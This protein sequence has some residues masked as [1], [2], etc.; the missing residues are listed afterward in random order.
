MPFQMT[1]VALASRSRNFDKA[2][3]SAPRMSVLQYPM[4]QSGMP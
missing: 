4:P 1:D 3:T 2:Y